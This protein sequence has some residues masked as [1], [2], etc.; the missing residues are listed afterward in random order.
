MRR[1]LLTA[2]VVVASG[3]AVPAVSAVSAAA[4]V[5]GP[6]AATDPGAPADG[7]PAADPIGYRDPTAAGRAAV[8]VTGT[9][10]PIESDAPGG[11]HQYLLDPGN[12]RVVPVSL[13]LADDLDRPADFVGR[14]ALG[15]TAARRAG[16]DSGERVAERS[17]EG[18]TALEA[19]SG[20]PAPLAV[21]SAT[22]T[23][24]ATT[25]ANA[26]TPDA[27]H[28]YVALVANRGTFDSTA[29]VQ[30]QVDAI[31]AYWQRESDGAITTFD[32]PEP[33]VRYASS[34]AGTLDQ[35]CGMRTASALWD[36]AADHFPGVRFGSDGNHLMVLVSD[37][38]SSHYGAG[39]GTIGSSIAS[40]G[41]SIVMLGSGAVQIGVHELGHNFS[42]MHANAQ[43]C[44][45]SCSTSGY[46]GLYSIMGLAVTGGRW[47]PPALDTAYR[48]ALGLDS[49]QSV[50][51]LTSSSV[52][53]L[54]GRGT[55]S[56]KR[57]AVV[58][59]PDSGARYVIDYRSGTGR[60]ATAFY[61]PGRDLGE[62]AYG[63]GVVVERLEN[64]GST[65]LLS[66]AVDGRNVT[67]FGA[68]RSIS[69]GSIAISVG[70]VSTSGGA[71][72]TV[73]LPGS[74]PPSDPG[75]EPRAL[76]AFSASA[77][78]IR[79]RAARVGEVLT[80]A[81]GRWVP[82][83]TRVAV[84]WLADG[85][86]VAGATSSRLRLTTALRGQR[87]SVR[88]TGSRPGYTSATR[89]SGST[90]RVASGRFSAHRP[91]VVGTAAVGR[92][93]VVRTHGWNPSPRLWVRWYVAGRPIAGATGRSLR[94]TPAL[95]GKRVT[96]RVAATRPGYAKR[97]VRSAPTHPVR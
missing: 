78:S 36:E 6:P 68:G 71:R 46:W 57:G 94:V 4:Q 56:G 43:I 27:H 42:L 33:T 55:G 2:A 40:G 97:T 23:P 50:P 20:A 74:T 85:R 30:G 45:S 63:P 92:T 38:C 47:T 26:V 58:V 5:P 83:P 88:V 41:R 79:G 39:L 8:D 75:S 9:L 13:D 32:Q 73:T 52:V 44:A 31:R 65:T 81:T 22:I 62:F 16:L 10:I 3:L 1:A 61:A 76:S 21:Q 24:Q 11:G 77:P 72:V 82:A 60:D 54:S 80:V 19:A 28:L 25:A 29:T 91:T 18:R 66:R 67:S 84:Q 64:D 90:S 86:P 70:S 93:L 35:G 14:V 49:P 89:T 53:T 37:D 12:G 15:A 17:A 51:T 95:R 48:L 87:I 96:V 69:A 7:A 34:V 59:D